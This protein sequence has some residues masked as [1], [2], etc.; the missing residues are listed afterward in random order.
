M[1][2]HFL[3]SS[4]LST[5]VHLRPDAWSHGATR[6]ATACLRGEM[7]KICRE[8]DGLWQYTPMQ[9]GHATSNIGNQAVQNTISILSSNNA[10]LFMWIHVFLSCFASEHCDNL[11]Q[12]QR[13]V[14]MVTGS[15]SINHGRTA[16]VILSSPTQ[17]PSPHKAK[18]K[19]PESRIRHVDFIADLLDEPV[20]NMLHQSVPWQRQ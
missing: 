1:S 19:T 17:M 15:T 3:Q 2:F 13:T 4:Q 14:P 16:A 7:R 12:Y 6:K 5:K 8:M 18:V 10:L 11:Q 9:Q 20:K